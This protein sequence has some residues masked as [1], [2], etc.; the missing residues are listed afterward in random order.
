MRQTLHQGH[1][2]ASTHAHRVTMTVSKQELRK[3]HA[4]RQNTS[5]LNANCGASH[6][7][8]DQIRW[9]GPPRRERAERER[10]TAHT[11]SGITGGL[12]SSY[13]RTFKSILDTW[14]RLTYISAARST[15]WHLRA[16]ASRF[17]CFFTT[18]SGVKSKQLGENFIRF[19]Q[20]PPLRG[21]TSFS[22]DSV[23]R[24]SSERQS[25]RRS[26]ACVTH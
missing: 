10:D 8:A 11:R 6:G 19:C 20:V 25:A 26:N 7:P 22:T 1:T 14:K 13:S 17:A 5:L 24:I 16:L 21:C 18:Q 4:S 9:S 2:R 12:E 3:S 15:C 23:E